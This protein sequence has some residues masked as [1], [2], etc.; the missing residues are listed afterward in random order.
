MLR[1]SIVIFFET[2]IILS[3]EDG[4]IPAVLTCCV[5]TPVVPLMG[6]VDFV[7]SQSVSTPGRRGLN[8]IRTELSCSV[9]LGLAC[10]EQMHREEETMVTEST[11]KTKK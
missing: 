7:N 4:M 3:R 10:R 5:R 9:H 1:C 8:A 2:N 11:Q 6:V